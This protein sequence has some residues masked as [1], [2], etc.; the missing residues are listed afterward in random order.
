MKKSILS[1]ICVFL[2]LA[3]VIPLLVLTA[4]PASADPGTAETRNYGSLTTNG[5]RILDAAGEGW[6]LTE[7]DL[8]ITYTLDMSGYVPPAWQTAWSAM[9]V[10]GGATGWLSS[11]APAAALSNPNSLNMADKLNLSTGPPWGEGGYDVV[12][13]TV[14]TAPIGEPTNNYGFWYDRDGVDPWQPNLWGMVNGGNYNTG[15]IYDIVFTL[16][17]LDATQGTMFCTVNGIKQGIF[18]TS[19]WKN[20]QP[21]NYPVGK[22]ITGDLTRL[23]VY[24]SVSGANV[25][26]LDI[27]ATGSP[28]ATPEIVWDNPADIVYGQALGAEQLNAT[29]LVDGEPVDGTFVYTPAAGTLLSAGN[30]QTLHV[31]FI[32][33]DAGS[34]NAASKDVFI[35]VL[36]A[37]TSAKLTSSM[38][39]GSFLGSIL[40]QR[41]V[42]TAS[43]YPVLPGAGTPTGTVT[44]MD[45]CK[46]LA[47]A[48]LV[49]GKATFKIGAHELG[50]TKHYM[51][52]VYSGDANF[53][54]S[55]SPVYFQ[56]VNLI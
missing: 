48:P 5:Y 51:T 15:G 10:T 20:A 27:T 44:F 16:H 36:K 38:N 30:G 34:F 41:I 25:Q 55:T 31:D 24:A 6:N 32:P 54:P 17:A 11:G 37:N 1:I 49:G 22:T 18:Q 45:G 8:V 56:N 13:D 33:T 2:L 42:F 3:G 28:V 29:A 39:P 9:G 35:N 23:Q 46:V 50:W 47:T 4:A 21:D 7:S 43:V 26:F 52:A 53:E 40:G 12:G 14:V 19:A